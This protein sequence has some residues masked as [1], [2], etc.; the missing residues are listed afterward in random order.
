MNLKR[1]IDAHETAKATAEALKQVAEKSKAQAVEDERLRVRLNAAKVQSVILDVIFPVLEEATRQLQESYLVR[2]N[3]VQ[4]RD[5]LRELQEFILEI[6]LTLSPKADE[7]NTPLVYRLSYKGFCADCFIF[8]SQ[9]VEGNQ[10]GTALPGLNRFTCGQLTS[11]I[12]ENQVEAFVL[13]VSR[14]RLELAE[15]KT[16]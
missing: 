1:I 15:R 2:T 9:D 8:A 3:Q 13:G 5:S 11:R 7:D 6:E 10:C 12:V 14:R 16:P 4:A